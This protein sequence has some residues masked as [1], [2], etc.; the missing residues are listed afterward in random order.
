MCVTHVLIISANTDKLCCTR[1][2]GTVVM[3]LKLN[4][5]YFS[6]PLTLPTHIN[7]V[8]PKDFILL[9]GQHNIFSLILH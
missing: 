8:D 9:F 1:A 3:S 6:V 7:M 2:E 5:K 4:I